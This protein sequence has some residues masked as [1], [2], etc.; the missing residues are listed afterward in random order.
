M[1]MVAEYLEKAHG[2]EQLAAYEQDA[3]LKK[4]LLAQAESYR[5]LAEKRAQAQN[6]PLPPQ[7]N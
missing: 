1:K 6:P 7:S 3:D 5:K 4:Q 2:F